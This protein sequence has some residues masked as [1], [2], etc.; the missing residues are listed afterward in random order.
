M[1]GKSGKTS[2]GGGSWITERSVFMPFIIDTEHGILKKYFPQ[3]GETEV[4]VPDGIRMIDKFAFAGC[5]NLYAVRIPEGLTNIGAGAFKNCKNLL[6]VKL[7]ESLARIGIEAFSG[8][9]S[10]GEIS[11]PEQVDTIHDLTFIACK[12]L[13]HAVLPKHMQKIGDKAF[14]GCTSLKKIR[15]PDTLHSLGVRAFCKCEKLTSV[16]IPEGVS[17]FGAYAFSDCAE[18]HFALIPE[19]VERIWTNVFPP[20]TVLHFSIKNQMFSVPFVSHSY[21]NHIVNAFCQPEL[22]QNTEI[23][24]RD[25][26]RQNDSGSLERFL[27]CGFVTD[28]K[29][30]EFIR[31]AIDNQKYE[32]QVVL[33]DYKHKHIGYHTQNWEL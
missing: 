12:N 25:F 5:D 2:R 21:S 19:S 18:L 4:T 28:Q 3:P 7:P 30:D 24:I 15:M 13:R 16:V 14:F 1:P 27:S 32:S 22:P 17:L 10:L 31:F 33:V 20:N 6:F 9:E 8:C 29:I 23:I 26:I 11:I